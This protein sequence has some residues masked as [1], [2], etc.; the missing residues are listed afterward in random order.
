[1][2]KTHTIGDGK[3]DTRSWADVAAYKAQLHQIL[4]SGIECHLDEHE[5]CCHDEH[6]TPYPEE[7]V[8]DGTLYRLVEMFESI[9]TACGNKPIKVNCAYR[10]PRHNKVV[11]GGEHSQ[12]LKGKALDLH[13][14]EGMT[15]ADFHEKIWTCAEQDG[16]RIGGIGVYDTF[17][18]VDIRDRLRGRIAR[19][20][21]R[22][23][24]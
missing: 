16:S 1:M 17:V 6:E 24:R 14:P 20:D 23:S 21:N 3:I 7:R 9:R 2:T 12:H 10:T 19:W 11:G 8:N 13:P 5:L 15:V 22:T 4:S 18:H